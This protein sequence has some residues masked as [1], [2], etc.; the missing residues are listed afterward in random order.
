M[1]PLQVF[2]KLRIVPL[3]S[4]RVTFF[5]MSVA[6]SNASPYEQASLLIL[7]VTVWKLMRS[8]FHKPCSTVCPG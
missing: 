4:L 5:L 2:Y 8:H 6:P 7:P 1:I 3:A